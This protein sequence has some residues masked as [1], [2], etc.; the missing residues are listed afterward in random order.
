M[1]SGR[2]DYKEFLQ[3]LGLVRDPRQSVAAKSDTG[4]GLSILFFRFFDAMNMI[5]L[6]NAASFCQNLNFVSLRVVFILFPS[7]YSPTF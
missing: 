1:R 2:L 3:R 6:T 7:R 4:A 5:S